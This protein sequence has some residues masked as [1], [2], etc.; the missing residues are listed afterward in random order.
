M[1]R[2]KV[3][4]DKRSVRSYEIVIG[5]DFMDRAGIMLAQGNWAKNYFVITDSNVSALHA[6]RIRDLLPAVDPEIATIAFPAGEKSK[7]IRTALTIV[8]E[9]IARGA[10]RESGLIGLGGGVAGDITG[11]VASTFMRGVPYVLIP[12]SLL[13]QV[14]SSIG[15]KT[16]VDL[17]AGKNLLGTFCQPRMVLT[18][19]AFLGTLPGREFTNGLAEIVKYAVIEDLDLLR[20]LEEGKEGVLGRD[21]AIMEAIVTRSCRI[22]K[23]IVEIDEN[24]RSIRRYLNFGHTIGHALEAESA[25]T[26]SHGEAV[27]AGM[28]A[29]VRISERMGYLAAGEA[30][31]IEALIGAMGLPVR[32]PQGGSTESVLSRLKVDKKKSG[33]RVHFVLL[34]SLG[35][36]F[37]NG[38]VPESMI[39]EVL[40]EL[41][42]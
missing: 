37:V 1:N 9:L 31:R 40:E 42:T 27:A 13:A 34:K 22:K 24:E 38:N 28:V 25:Y 39:G 16:S 3:N 8:D 41:K 7:D 18:D 17:P 14:D 11:F 23:A 35:V 20:L 26:L 10:D 33:D 2:I 12:T 36:P 29:A 15:G 6:D 4:L 21:A 32:T 19:L 30:R 5:R